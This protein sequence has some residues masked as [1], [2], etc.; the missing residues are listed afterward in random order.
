M[1]K[2]Q[3]DFDAS[4]CDLSLCKGLQFADNAANIQQFTAGQVLPMTVQIK[5]PHTGDANVSV[6]DTKTNSVIGTPMIEWPV[7]AS[8][9]AGIPENNTEFEVTL[10]NVGD[11]CA[12]A[13]DCVLQW[14]WD[15]READQTYMS[16]VDFTM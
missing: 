11:Q 6:V 7:Y 2:S 14:W 5:A 12:T 3:T 9:S 16:C 15:S 10:P 8:N 13:G 4:A 1:V